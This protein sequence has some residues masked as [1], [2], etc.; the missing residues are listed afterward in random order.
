VKQALL[1]FQMNRGFLV[2]G[3]GGANK[4]RYEPLKRNVDPRAGHM[5]DGSRT[6][7]NGSKCTAGLHFFV[8]E[9]SAFQYGR[10]EWTKDQ[11]FFGVVTMRL[12]KARGLVVS[13][14]DEAELGNGQKQL[15]THQEIMKNALPTSAPPLAERTSSNTLEHFLLN[16]A[17]QAK[18]NRGLLHHAKRLF[19]S[20]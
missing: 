6:T 18:A 5:P 20:K 19:G 17:E 16:M 15:E 13:I 10:G 3:F 12:S 4:T 14:S 11:C 8:D 2:S 7:R 1:D 9:Q